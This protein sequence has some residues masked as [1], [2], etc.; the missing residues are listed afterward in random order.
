MKGEYYCIFEMMYN[1]EYSYN[2]KIKKQLSQI[3]LYNI[4]M[5]NYVLILAENALLIYHYYHP[6]SL[7]TEKYDVVDPNVVNERI[8]DIL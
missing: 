5:I 6:T 2:S 4:Q 7:S 3:D 1:Y 8:T